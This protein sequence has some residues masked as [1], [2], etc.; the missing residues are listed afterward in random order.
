MKERQREN[1]NLVE[2]RFVRNEI[3][4]RYKANRPEELKKIN[5]EK[6]IYNENK[7]DTKKTW[8]RL[9]MRELE[10][11]KVNER[12]LLPNRSLD[13]IGRN[14]QNEDNIAMKEPQK[15]Q[16]SYFSIN[17]NKQKEKPEILTRSTPNN[18]LENKI[19]DNYALTKAHYIMMGNVPKNI[20]KKDE[21]KIA[22]PKFEPKAE[23]K[24]EKNLKA[25]KNRVNQ[26]EITNKEK[27]KDLQLNSFRYSTKGTEKK[28]DKEEK[29]LFNTRFNEIDNQNGPKR[30]LIKEKSEGFIKTKYNRE[31]LGKSPKAKTNLNIY[32]RQPQIESINKN[33]A[34]RNRFITNKEKDKIKDQDKDSKLYIRNINKTSVDSRNPDK[35]QIMRTSHKTVERSPQMN[36]KNDTENIRTKYNSKKEDIESYPTSKYGKKAYQKP[37]SIP[38]SYNKSINSRSDINKKEEE[39]TSKISK[40]LK[41]TTSQGNLFNMRKDLNLNNNYNYNNNYNIKSGNIND[42]EDKTKAKSKTIDKSLKNQRDEQNINQ[43]YGFINGANEK[44]KERYINKEKEDK[45]RKDRENRFEKEKIEREKI[46][47]ERQEKLKQERD[48]KEFEKQKEK[49]KRE[50]E[51]KEKERLDNERKER[52]KKEKEKEKK[53]RERIEKEKKDKMEKERIEREKQEKLERQRK[54]QERQNKLEKERRERERTEK[55]RQ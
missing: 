11:P 50:K 3:K 49:E 53:E 33:E 2:N 22:K 37:D 47:R 43:K 45:E 34:L 46:E 32:E 7:T 15:S 9:S 24:R 31:N 30:S 28:K 20:E 14:Y 42:K 8:N 23:E 12:I 5:S 54:E 6:S 41:Y 27:E 4:E 51:R 26:I 36:M 13:R 18:K 29:K 55:E 16:Q 17:K 35:N 40:G 25:F 10:S 48:K 19:E 1:S 38:T 52:E 39:K 44:L 21:F